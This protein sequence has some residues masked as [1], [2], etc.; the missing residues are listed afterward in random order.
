MADTESDEFGAKGD[1]QCLPGGKNFAT[2]ELGDRRLKRAMSIGYVLSLDSAK[3]C[4][5]F[6]VVE[7]HSREPMSFANP[8]WN[9][10]RDRTALSNDGGECCRTQSGAMRWRRRLFLIMAVLRRKRRLRVVGRERSSIAQCFGYRT[11]EWSILGLLSQNC[12][13][14]SK[15]KAPQD[16]TNQAEKNKDKPQ[17][18]KTQNRV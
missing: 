12:G 5:K 1:K 15:G 18:V 14:G 7:Q 11:A 10:Q 2:L 4:Q 9:F 16:E 17:L 6:S 13:I 8:K 3:H